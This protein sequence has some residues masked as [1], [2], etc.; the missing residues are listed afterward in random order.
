ML[1]A[2]G[3]QGRFLVGLNRANVTPLADV[4]TTLIVVFLI[5][6]PAIMWNGIQVKSAAAGAEQPVLTPTV[7]ASDQIVT[8]QVTPNGLSVNDEPVA[9]ADLAKVLTVRLAALTDKTVVVV[10]GDQVEFGAVVTVLDVAKAS[11]AEQVAL[12]NEIEGNRD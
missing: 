12:L 6:M 10:P 3:R 11:G 4:T 5:T 7:K 9:A 1:K 8:V 2:A